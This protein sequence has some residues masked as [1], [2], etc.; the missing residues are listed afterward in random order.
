MARSVS[1]LTSRF[2]DTVKT[3]GRHWDGGGLFLMV[4]KPGKKLE[5]ALQPLPKS[6]GFRYRDGKR[7]RDIGLG[8]IQGVTL[9]E[10]REKAAECRAMLAKGVDP[11]EARRTEQTK[12]AGLTFR[13]AAEQLHASKQT[14][15]R[16]AKHIK[17]WLTALETHAAQIMNKPVETITVHDV[18]AV[19]QPIWTLRAETASRVRGRI[20]QVLDAAK[21]RGL[22][23]EDRA[24]PA[25]WKG[26]LQ[27][28]LG[29]RNLLQRGHFRALPWRDV[30]A[31]MVRL[32]ERLAVDARCLE[33]V[34]LTGSRS[35]EAL[36]ARWSEIDIDQR[37]WAVP[38]KRMKAGRE[39]RVP[40]SDRALAIL[41]DMAVF[42]K[43][44]DGYVFP[45]RK[46]GKPLSGMALEMLLRRMEVAAT[47]HG[48]RSSLR[49]WAGDATSFP[50]EIAEGALAHVIGNAVEQ[51][52]RRSDAIEKLR[53]F[54]E[55]W[56][57]Y[58]AGSAGADVVP[59][60]RRTG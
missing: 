4:G 7:V 33:Y 56:A 23:A 24:N 15:W 5:G 25:R 48:F 22:I 43:E 58:C 3:P 59:L 12:P 44:P 28:I 29:K 32:R 60:V 16:N 20:E 11:I 42:R 26:H 41:A 31:F 35:G 50:R 10:A 54:V 14:G 27:H 47:P 9:A 2:C 6:W 45:G 53:Q 52:Y 57:G 37:L 39:H 17:Q 19:L 36:G 34:I 55:A 49:D 46:A 30:P 40:L 21:V 18:V 13:Q 51:A 8:A 1:R 38:A